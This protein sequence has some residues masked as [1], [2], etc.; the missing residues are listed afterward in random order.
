MCLWL[1]ENAFYLRDTPFLQNTGP[2]RNEINLLESLMR[3]KT[4]SV[5]A[6]CCQIFFFSKFFYGCLMV[7]H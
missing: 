2:Y 1:I 7:S 6:Q 4:C 5:V 3:E